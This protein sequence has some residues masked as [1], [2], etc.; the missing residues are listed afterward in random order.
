MFVIY[1]EVN[2]F[3]DSTLKTAGNFSK[4]FC[5]PGFNIEL[6]ESFMKRKSFRLRPDATDISHVR[7][8]VAC[9]I[10]NRV[11]LPSIQSTFVRLTINGELYGL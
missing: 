6:S 10:M 7:Q 4:S 5:K 1:S 11:G 8:K 3:P 2:E 9:D